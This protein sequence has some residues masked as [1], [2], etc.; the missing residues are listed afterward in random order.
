MAHS[1]WAPFGS[2]YQ[3]P[4][5]S[6]HKPYTIY[7]IRRKSPPSLLLALMMPNFKGSSA[8]GISISCLRARVG[9]LD[10]PDSPDWVTA[11]IPERVNVC[12]HIS[13]RGGH[14]LMLLVIVVTLVTCT[15]RYIRG[16]YEYKGRSVGEVAGQGGCAGLCWA[17]QR[18]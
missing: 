7:H 6:Y 17:G 15:L 12:M 14:A 13:A 18:V 4:V 10:S 1:S 8:Q 9:L 3:L 11:R 16:V 2:G 5:T